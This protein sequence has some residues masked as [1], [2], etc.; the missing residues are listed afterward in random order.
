MAVTLIIEAQNSGA[1]LFKA[2]EVLEISVSTFRRWSA[3]NLVDCRKGAS[4]QVPGKLSLEEEQSIINICCSNEYKDDNPYKIHASLL[5][6]GTYIASI[7]SFYR[8]LRKK[9]LMTHRGNTKPAQ[10]HSKPPEKIATGPNQVWCWDITWCSSD[11]RGLFYYAYV[12]IDIWDRSIVKWAIHDREDDA[13]SE[14]LF[15]HALRDNNYPD[16]WVHSDNGNP[17][18]GITLLALFYHLGICNSYSRPRVSNDNPFI[19]SWFKTLKYNVSYPGKFS[20]I[21]NAREWFAGFVNS[22]N[23][24]HS[25]SG[26]HFITPQQVRNGHYE[27]IV[28]KRNKVMKKAKNKNPLRWSRHVKQLPVKHTVKL[29]S[30]SLTGV[31]DRNKKKLRAA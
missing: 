15:K 5:D 31:S 12:I 14:E 21:E 2:C 19:E 4:K 18:K 10:C 8:V 24:D 16:V 1:R 30:V 23:T 9:G 25:H 17:M 28:A 11:V 26:V 29:N 3:G 7:S 20:S 27:S 13:L 6:K 22:Y